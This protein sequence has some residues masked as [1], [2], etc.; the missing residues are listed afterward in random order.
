MLRLSKKMF[1]AIEAVLYIAYNGAGDPVSS[2][3]IAKRQNLPPRYLEQIMQ[4]L[5]HA[6]ILRGVRG[7]KGGYL[8]ARERRR[9]PLG[10][11]C[12]VI[13]NMDPLE[14]DKY[15]QTPL[16]REIAFPLYRRLEQAMMKEL[17]DT[18]IADLCQQAEDARV[19]RGTE[20][21]VDFTI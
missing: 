7:P 19:P 5:V 20:D 12:Q 9:I 3:E 16:S 13:R 11:I 10:E 15:Q 1:Y 21:A 6:G 8:L 14:L 18:N 4:A 2:K 17:K